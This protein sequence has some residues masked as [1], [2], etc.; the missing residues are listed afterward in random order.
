[1]RAVYCGHYNLERNEV[2]RNSTDLPPYG[3]QAQKSYRTVIM[4]PFDNVM[5]TTVK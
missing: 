1:M 2:A 3:E 5:E 4:L